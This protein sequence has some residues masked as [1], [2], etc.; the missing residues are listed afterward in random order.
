[1]G[2]VQRDRFPFIV[3]TDDPDGQ[4][5][6]SV[7]GVM[8]NMA[9]YR[10]LFAIKTQN[11][12]ETERLDGCFTLDGE[13][14]TGFEELESGSGHRYGV[15]IDV[16]PF[17]T[18]FFDSETFNSAVTSFEF[19]GICGI[20]TRDSQNP[21]ERYAIMVAPERYAECMA[22]FNELDLDAGNTPYICASINY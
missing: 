6:P 5:I 8:A 18:A 22:L 16:T 7:N 17:Q 11:P 4:Y 15:Y 1:M 14:V 3:Y 2:L 10:M 21:R 9:P 12:I 19:C 13:A 20:S